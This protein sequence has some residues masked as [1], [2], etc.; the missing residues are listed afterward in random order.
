M[1]SPAWARLREAAALCKEMFESAEAWS[2]PMASSHYRGEIADRIRKLEAFAVDAEPQQP[3]EARERAIEAWRECATE[4]Q[5]EH[6]DDAGQVARRL[7]YCVTRDEIDEAVA[8]MRSAPAQ[9]PV[10]DT[11]SISCKCGARFAIST[12]WRINDGFAQVICSACGSEVVTME[13]LVTVP[14]E[15]KPAIA[16]HY[17]EHLFHDDAGMPSSRCKVCDVVYKEAG[18]VPCKPKPASPASDDSGVKVALSK[19][20]RRVHAQQEVIDN[21]LTKQ[22]ALR[23]RIKRLQSYIAKIKAST[24]QDAALPSK[25]GLAGSTPAAGSAREEQQDAR[26]G[27]NG[28]VAGSSPAARSISE[29]ASDWRVR[30][31][32]WAEEFDGTSAATAMFQ[33]LHDGLAALEARVARLEGPA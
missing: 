21:L 3:D 12:R 29:P 1:T 9:Q 10:P 13:S 5:R 4:H 16:D 7:I 19:A 15:P 2:G 23:H 31:D 6:P 25:Q 8:L 32:M 28:E 11:P 18:F 30:F 27:P 33:A 26:P 14:E 24:Q 17:E 22:G 20:S